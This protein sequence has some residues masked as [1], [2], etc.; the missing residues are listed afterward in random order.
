MPKLVCLQLRIARCGHYYIKNCI[1]LAHRSPPMNP[2]INTT[3]RRGVYPNDEMWSI[4]L[5]KVFSAKKLNPNL[6]SSFFGQLSLK[7]GSR[8]PEVNIILRTLR[9]HLP[10]SLSHACAVEVSTGYLA[11][12]VTR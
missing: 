11:Y 8:D 10:F 3:T 1:K 12:D 4:R 5:H 9:H 2:R 7:V 6:E